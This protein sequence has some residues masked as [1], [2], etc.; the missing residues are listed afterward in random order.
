MSDALALIADVADSRNIHDFPARRDRLLDEVSARHRELGWSGVA[1][2]VTAWDE[3]QGLIDEP[4]RLPLVVWD[5]W[6]TFQPWSLRL[7]F[8]IGAVER[9]GRVADGLPLNRAV[10]G[11]AFF[12]A[13]SALDRL[14]EPR[15]GLGRVRVRVAGDDASR[16]SACNGVLRL[17][18]AL[19]GDITDRQWQV[20]GEYE[21]LGKQTDVA[22]RLEVSESTVSRTLAVSRYWEIKASLSDLE[23][24][25]A[26]RLRDT[27]SVAGKGVR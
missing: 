18:D 11:E 10:T 22:R 15:H 2:A 24:T 23:R 3:F 26:R 6:R 9:D 17:A 4:D 27:R 8:G 13:R 21:Q 19:V 1:Y 7:G 20:I 16:V 5:F 25:L 12:H 14:S